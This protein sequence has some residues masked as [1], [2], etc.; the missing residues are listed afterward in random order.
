VDVGLGRYL[1]PLPCDA[2]GFEN[3]GHSH[4]AGGGAECNGGDTSKTRIPRCIFR[5][6][7][8][9]WWVRC[10]VQPA[11]PC[12]VFP[13]GCFPLW[14]GFLQ[15][16]KMQKRILQSLLAFETGHDRREQQAAGKGE[17]GG[18]Q[19]GV[20]V[21]RS[22][23]KGFMLKRST[24]NE[25]LRALASLQSPRSTFV[26]AIFRRRHRWDGTFQ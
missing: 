13:A 7:F 1:A 6:Y 2:N 21:C 24:R 3:D 9:T 15:P 20:R 25:L 4:A 23:V 17:E 10:C 16:S 12:V 19:S 18:E 14:L 5:F 22:R 11:P 8:D 26:F